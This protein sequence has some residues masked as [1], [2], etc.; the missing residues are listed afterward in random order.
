MRGCVCKLV[1]VPGYPLIEQPLAR[2]KTDFLYE[3]DMDLPVCPEVMK[4]GGCA[5]LLR[6][7]DDEVDFALGGHATVVVYCTRT[8][9]IPK[10]H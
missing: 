8:M 9:P 5:G 2:E 10:P 1:Q 6:S 4:K 7:Y 3:R